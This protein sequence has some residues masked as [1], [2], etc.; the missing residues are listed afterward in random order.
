M[1]DYVLHVLYGNESETSVRAATSVFVLLVV[2]IV[3]QF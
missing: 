1:W 3:R 2:G